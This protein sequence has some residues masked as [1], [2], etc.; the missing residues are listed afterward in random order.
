MDCYFPQNF[1]QKGRSIKVTDSIAKSQPGLAREVFERPAHFRIGL[2]GD[3][4]T[5]AAGLD[6]LGRA[7]DELK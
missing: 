2:G 4:E 5:L 1:A 7:L 3:R 6:R